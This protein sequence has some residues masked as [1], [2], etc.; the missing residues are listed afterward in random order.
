MVLLHSLVLGVFLSVLVS[1]GCA[2]GTVNNT[3]RGGVFEVAW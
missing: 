2:G 1:G 3:V